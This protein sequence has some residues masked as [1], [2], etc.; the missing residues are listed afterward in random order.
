MLIVDIF[1]NLITYY[2]LILLVSQVHEDT[3]LVPALCLAQEVLAVLHCS[4]EDLHALVRVVQRLAR[5][6]GTKKAVAA[7]CV[8]LKVT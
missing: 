4:E 2:D 5:K 6:R 1:L 7:A 3:V 8:C